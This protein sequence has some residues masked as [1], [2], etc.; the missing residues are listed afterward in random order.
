MNILVVGNGFDLAHGLPTHYEDFIKFIELVES[1]YENS[2]NTDIYS[3]VKSDNFNNLNSIQKSYFSAALSLEKEDKFI[4]EFIQLS[5]NN[6]WIKH[7]KQCI[8]NNELKGENW[9]DFES[10]ITKIV[11]SLEYLKDYNETQ[12]KLISVERKIA[13]NYEMYEYGQKFIQGI[14]HKLIQESLIQKNLE[15]ESITYYKTENNSILET[16]LF[17]KSVANKVISFLIKELNSLNRCLEIYLDYFIKFYNSN[18]KPLEDIIKIHNIDKLISFNYTNTFQYMYDKEHK[19]EYDYIHGQSRTKRNIT[20]NN[21]V[22]GIDEYLDDENKDKK[23]DFIEFKKYY[24][25]IY[26]N[27]GCEYKKWIEE[28]EESNS[29]SSKSTSSTKFLN[30]IY[31]YGHSLDITDKDILQELIM[32]PK[33]QIT[34]FYHNQKNYREKISN[35]VGLIGQDY[36]CSNVRG[37]NPKIIFKEITK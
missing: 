37:S 24:Q 27:T 21:M 32:L 30:N 17:S 14:N 23:R 10:E 33:S 12:L 8:Q 9:I 35:L 4:Q 22:L 20:D 11:K 3:F 19:I 29:I 36:L 18:N 16:M 34:I 5:S 15:E 31:F 26:K 13:N 7:F 2:D 25:R 28:M 6:I 1:Y